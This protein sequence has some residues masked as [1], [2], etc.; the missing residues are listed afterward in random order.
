MFNNEFWKLVPNSGTASL[1][2]V[3]TLPTNSENTVCDNKM[4]TPVRKLI[5]I[6][7]FKYTIKYFA[8][9]FFF[10]FRCYM[11]AYLLLETLQRRF[12]INII[13]SLYSEAYI[14]CLEIKDHLVFIS[15]LTIRILFRIVKLK[16]IV[17]NFVIFL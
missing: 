7:K 15:L 4:V 13:D 8:S 14:W 16:K 17:I 5:V 1:V 12:R 6:I 2:F 11:F 3:I 9:F 10:F